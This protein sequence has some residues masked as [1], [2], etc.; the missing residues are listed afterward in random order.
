MGKVYLGIE[1][2]ST[3]IKA[4]LV[5]G[6]HQVVASGSHQWENVLEGGLWTYSLEAVWEGVRHSVGALL[7]SCPGAIDIG[8]IGV[9]AMMH[10]YLAFDDGGRLLTPFRTWR[11]TTTEVAA[12]ALTELFQFN[13]P[14]RWSIAHLY[15]AMLDQ[16]PHVGDIA[17]IT[18]LAGYVHW[19]LTGEKIL[20]VGDASGV[21]PLDEAGYHRGMMGQFEGLNTYP[22]QLAD[23]LPQVKMAGEAGGVLTPQGAALLDPTGRIAPGIPLCPPEGDAG[24]GMVCTN[25]IGEGTGNISAGTSIFAMIVLERPLSKV[26]M[27]IDMV[28]TP[29]GKPVAMVHCNNCSG[30]IDAWVRLFAENLALFGQTPTLDDLY[31]TLYLAALQGEADGGGILTYNFFAGEPMIALEAGRPM[32]IREPNGRFTLANTM[33]SLVMSALGTLKIGMDILA[34]ENV[35]LGKLL[36]HGGF[37]KSQGV[38]Q[39]L[40]AAALEVPVSVM[41]TAGEGGPWGM[42]VLATY[43]AQKSPEQTLEQYLAQVFA[44]EAATTIAPVQAD[45]EGFRQYMTHYVEGLVA[46]RAAVP[47]ELTVESILPSRQ[48]KGTFPKD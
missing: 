42:A 30:D 18:T 1:L 10:G 34:S 26:H 13:I 37:F 46:A 12:G 41:A 14:Q 2:G 25:S 5:D 6:N 21:F 40:M 44:N 17:F 8:G 4:V 11:N 16:E 3:R 29:A 43:M 28:T 36:G 19:Q 39:Q 27:E 22:W 7:D 45:V 33:R 9:S 38:G 47:A 23:I 15:Q 48:P 35:R 20:G 31:K 24:T 32:L